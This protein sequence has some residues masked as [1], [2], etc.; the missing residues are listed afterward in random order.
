M[1]G[2]VSVYVH[3]CGYTYYTLTQSLQNLF[4]GWPSLRYTKTSESQFKIKAS[5]GSCFT[6][7]YEYELNKIDQVK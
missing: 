5:V 2:H 3:S 4:K 1:Y 6:L 7:D